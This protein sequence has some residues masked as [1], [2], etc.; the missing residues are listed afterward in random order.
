MT[1]GQR[2]IFVLIVCALCMFGTLPSPAHAGFTEYSAI[3]QSSNPV[4][5]WHLSEGTGPAVDAALGDS[6]ADDGTYTGGFTFQQDSIWTGAEAAGDTAPQFNGSSAHVLVPDS[7]EI[8]L[9]TDD[10]T[11]SM[12]VRKDTA[13]TRKFIYNHRPTGG[14]DYFEISWNAGNRIVVGSN[15]GS[16]WGVTSDTPLAPNTWYHL[17]ASID[18]DNANNSR[19]YI[20]GLV[21]SPSATLPAPGQNLDIAAGSSI[22]RWTGGAAQFHWDGRIDEPAIFK[23][24]LSGEQLAAHYAAA[25]GGPIVVG[26]STYRDT[27]LADGPVGYW[28]LDEQPPADGPTRNFKAIA[29]LGSQTDAGSAGLYD[30]NLTSGSTFG[31]SGPR[32]AGLPGFETA[33]RAARFDGVDDI[34]FVP[35]QPGYQITGELTM[36]A[37]VNP[38]DLSGRPTILSKYRA[39]GFERSYVMVLETDGRL[40]LTVSQDGTFGGAGE[41]LSGTTV[42][43]GQWT[44]VAAT[45]KPDEYMRVYIN[46]QPVGELTELADGVPSGIQSTSQA[47]RIGYLGGDFNFFDGLLDEIALYNTALSDAQIAAHYQAAFVPEPGTFALLGLGGAGLLA[48]GRRRQRRR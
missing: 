25:V 32:P 47:V 18:R 27:V 21:D 31:V 1:P 40:N 48:F 42:P 26:S 19:I 46:G 24:A 38:D 22:G 33:N 41:L 11:I 44:H 3:V 9:G 13:D 28:R 43:T 7:S 2:C 30:F 15:V 8:S 10:F 4:A 16:V 34:G 20:N 39:E 36:E 14:G 5:Y 23:S 12:F 37:W 45:F 35:N 29:N 17:A 6:I